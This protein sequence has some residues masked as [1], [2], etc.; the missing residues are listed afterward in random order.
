MI[1]Q[2]FERM[3]FQIKAKHRTAHYTYEYDVCVCV[4]A[5]SSNAKCQIRPL[6]HTLRRHSAM[7]RNRNIPIGMRPNKMANDLSKIIRGFTLFCSRSSVGLALVLLTE[8][9]NSQCV[10]FGSIFSPLFFSLF[11]HYYF[12]KFISMRPFSLGLVGFLHCCVLH[13][14]AVGASAACVRCPTHTHTHI[15]AETLD[16]CELSLEL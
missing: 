6:T 8:E 4:V 9:R 7:D 2:S 1:I 3:C 14:E 13:A 16:L 5:I 15:V 12:Q 10:R 11:F